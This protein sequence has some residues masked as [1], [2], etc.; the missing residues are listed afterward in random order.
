MKRLAGNWE[1]SADFGQGIQKIKA[2]YKL[3]SGNSAIIETFHVGTPHEMVSVYHDNKSQKLTMTHYCAE[4]NQPKLI[5]SEWID[6]K[7]AM[8][9]AADN[10][11]DV[12]HESHIH[13]AAIQFEG[14]DS[15]THKWTSFKD[16]KQ[17]QVVEIIFKRVN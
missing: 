13:A 17:A 5:L 12:V 3:T 1:G 4:H 11:I 9:F 10:E 15:M 14:E 7:L 2:H 16:G 6:N 8:D